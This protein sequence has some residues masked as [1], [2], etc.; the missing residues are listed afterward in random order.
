MNIVVKTASGKYI[1][2]PDTTWERDNEDLFLPEFVSG[3]SWTPVLFARI[4]KPGRSVGERFG[5]RY[6]DGI[7]YGVLLYPEDMLDG[8]EE[9][10]ACA[11]CLDHTSFLPF[12][13][14]EKQPG[15]EGKFELEAVRNGE[16]HKLFSRSGASPEEIRKA[17]AEATRFIYIRIGDLIAIEL[18]PRQ[19]LGGREDSSISVKGLFEGSAVIDFHIDF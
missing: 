16:V 9:G 19:H 15:F 4:S 12:P 2:R 18:Q 13:V 5:E 8:S 11:S 6:Y 3:L 17:I 10:F 7:G 14:L 1:V